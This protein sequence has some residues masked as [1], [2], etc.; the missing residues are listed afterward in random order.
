MTIRGKWIA[1]EGGDGSGK[2]TQVALLASRLAWLGFHT[3]V[4]KAPGGTPVGKE[5]RSRLVEAAG[6][7]DALTEEAIHAADLALLRVEI[8]RRLA[9]GQWVI[10]DRSHYSSYAYSTHGKQNPVE[11]EQL[12]RAAMAGLEPDVLVH[13][14]IDVAEGRRRANAARGNADAITTYD[15][16]DLDFYRRIRDYYVYDMKPASGVPVVWVSVDGLDPE[17][18]TREILIGLLTRR[19]VIASLLEY[20]RVA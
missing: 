20:G 16:A 17:A 8:E 18:V 12:F 2:S 13:L 5:L 19:S 9:E 3:W 15:E 4:S 6:T 7:M 1:I 14:D 11:W 10:T